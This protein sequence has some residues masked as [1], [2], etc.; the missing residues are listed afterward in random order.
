MLT[1]QL[2]AFCHEYLIDYN[3]KQA[4][5]RAGYSAKTAAGQASMILTRPA[6]RDYLKGL[7]DK[8]NGNL[9]IDAERVLKELARLAFH[10]VGNYYKKD[11]KGKEV[12][13][14]LDE[15]TADQRAAIVEYDPKTKSMKLAS[16]DGALDKLAKHLKIYTELHEN[17]Y[18][19]NIMPELKLGGKT[20]IFNVGQ[21]KPKK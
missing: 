2:K 6:V 9:A 18:N 8:K 7:T 3:G 19:F 16:K 11:S 5:I 15:L 14:D 10:D 12:L 4:A 1:E 21:P 20:V 17:E 13:K